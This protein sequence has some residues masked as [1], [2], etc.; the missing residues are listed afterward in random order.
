[1][2]GSFLCYDAANQRRSKVDPDEANLF[3]KKLDC[4]APPEDCRAWL[5]D[6]DLAGPRRPPPRQWL[7]LPDDEV[8]AIRAAVGSGTV[9]V[10]AMARRLGVTP[11]AVSFLVREVTYKHV[12]CPNHSLT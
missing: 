11:M 3:W 2:S 7:G 8:C 5:G 4:S 9:G 6:L 1:M 12:H 10:R